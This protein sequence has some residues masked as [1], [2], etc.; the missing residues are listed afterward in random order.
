MLYIKGYM[1]VAE[2]LADK[3][4][5]VRDGFKDNLVGILN[6]SPCYNG[7]NSQNLFT[8]QGFYNIMLLHPNR[9][10][11]LYGHVQESYLLSTTPLEAKIQKGLMG[12]KTGLT[13]RVSRPW[14]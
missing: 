12:K 2:C 9:W 14:F 8:L 10:I 13:K 6:Y 11:K 1:P 4:L 5:G 3:G 7:G